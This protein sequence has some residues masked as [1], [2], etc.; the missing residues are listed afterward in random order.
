MKRIGKVIDNISPDEDGKVLVKIYPEL[1]DVPDGDLPWADP[2]RKQTQHVVPHIGSFVFVQ[3]SPDWTSFQ[4]SQES[5]YISALY[6]YEDIREAMDEA[7]DIGEHEYPE[8]QATMMRD[9]SVYFHNGETSECGIIHS[10]GLHIII[11]DDGSFSIKQGED[12]AIHYDVDEK[13]FE[14]GELETIR[15]GKEDDLTILF[16][17]EDEQILIENI[18]ELLIP[19]ITDIIIGDEGID[20]IKIGSNPKKIALYPPLKNILDKLLTHNHIAPTG[21]TTPA[22]EPSGTPLS[23]Y[24]GDLPDIESEIVETD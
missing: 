13:H 11:Q 3:V 5:P 19:E 1:I 14:I 2:V 9:G 15:I 6:P 16:N 7:E 10:T 8:P 4:Y 24:A 12:I 21:P 22:Q 18:E 17:A 20:S 23:A